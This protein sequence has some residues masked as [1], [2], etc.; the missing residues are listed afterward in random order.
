MSN[1]LVVEDAM[2]K[3]KEIWDPIDRLRD[4]YHKY[5]PDKY[6]QLTAETFGD[7]SAC[8]HHVDAQLTTRRFYRDLEG[9][10]CLYR[11]DANQNKPKPALK[12]EPASKLATSK[13]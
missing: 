7:V 6:H 3:L 2:M 11:R 8:I 4:L 12:P 1:D 5:R 13:N 9:N 10:H